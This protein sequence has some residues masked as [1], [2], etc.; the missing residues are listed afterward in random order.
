MSSISIINPASFKSFTNFS[1]ASN[2]SSPAY[3]PHNS[4]KV[5]SLLITINF[6]KLCLFPTS[7]SFASCAG[8]ILTVPLPILISACLSGIIGIILPTIGM[9]TFFPITLL[10]L[11]SKGFTATATSP[12]IVSGLVVAIS[13]Y[14]SLSS[15]KYFI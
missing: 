4:F 7:K 2:L 6:S 13:I 11:L 14:S 5:P 10:Y 8:V 3:S 12:N 15:R 9:I 1:L